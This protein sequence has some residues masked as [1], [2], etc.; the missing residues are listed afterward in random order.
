MANS[1]LKRALSR[2]LARL[3]EPSLLNG[4]D[5]GNVH[6]ARDVDLFAGDMDQSN[7]NHMVRADVA[8]IEASYS[9]KT[10][11]LLEH[12][13]GEFRLM[14]LVKDNGYTRAFIVIAT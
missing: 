5:C 4:A 9:P 12:P 6:L 13:D 2:G 8:T 3:G 14:R 1:V 7:D 10:G 11:D